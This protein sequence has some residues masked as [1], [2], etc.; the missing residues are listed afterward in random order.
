M[1][2]HS[3]QDRICSDRISQPKSPSDQ[4][5]T[6]TTSQTPVPQQQQA[7]SRFADYFVICGLDLDTGL[8]AD[9]FAGKCVSW[10]PLNYLFITFFSH[11]LSSI[12]FIIHFMMTCYFSQI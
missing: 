10:N 12:I 3:Q 11:C 6:T 8:E 4:Q 1:G 9:R 2:E 5:T 7:T